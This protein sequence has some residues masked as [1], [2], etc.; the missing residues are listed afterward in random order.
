MEAYFE[1]VGAEMEINNGTSKAIKR[2]QKDCLRTFIEC[3]TE[4]KQN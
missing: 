1:D 2:Q 3:N 4:T